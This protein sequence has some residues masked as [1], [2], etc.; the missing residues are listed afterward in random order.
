MGFLPSKFFDACPIGFATFTSSKDVAK[1][2]YRKRGCQCTAAPSKQLDV[3]AGY[4][5]SVKRAV[6]YRKSYIAVFTFELQVSIRSMIPS[7]GNAY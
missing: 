7:I 5:G 1:K 6:Q 2:E 4:D 3:Y